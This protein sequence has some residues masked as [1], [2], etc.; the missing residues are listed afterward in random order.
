MS[1]IAP[2]RMLDIEGV[3]DPVSI[4]QTN[5]EILTQEVFEFN[6]TYQNGAETTVIGPP[7]T[8][9]HTVDEKWRDAWMAEWRCTVAGTPGTWRQETPAVRAGEP[10]S[11]TIPTNYII[12]D[13]NENYVKK[14]HAGS[15]VWTDVYLTNAYLA[16]L[17]QAG[18]IY[19]RNGSNVACTNTLTGVLR[20]NGTSGPEVI[21]GLTADRIARI[22]T[23]GQTLV[24]SIARDDGTYFAVG[25][26]IDTGQQTFQVTGGISLI[27]ASTIKT[28]IGELT[29]DTGNSLAINFKIGG[30]NGWRI[31]SAS[32]L[33]AV[34]AQT[35]STTTGNLSLTPGTGGNVY[36]NPDGAV[37]IDPIDVPTTVL[38][39][40]IRGL[41][42]GNTST[43]SRV[44]LISTTSSTTSALRF[45][46]GGG[47]NWDQGYILY[48]HSADQMDFGTART[49]WWSI[50]SV[51][52]L[53]SN[54][55]QTI[56]SSSGILTVTGTGGLTL[57][58]AANT[59]IVFTPHGTGKVVLT[60]FT[61][62]NILHIGAGGI[63]TESSNLTWEA[64]T[65]E[66]KLAGNAGDFCSTSYTAGGVTVRNGYRSGTG[67]YELYS[68]S[69]MLSVHPTTFLV[70]A[71]GGLTFNNA[72][73]IQTSSGTLTIQ[74]N[75]GAT[76][77]NGDTK[78]GAAG[79]TQLAKLVVTRT[80]AALNG[81]LALVNATAAGAD[82][83]TALE[84][85][86]VS[87]V[88]MGNIGVAWNG[89]ATTDAYM[90]FYTRG[91]GSTGEKLRITSEGNVGL[92]T[93]SFG[94]N[95]A[96]VLAIANGTAP[97]TGPSDTVQFY[98][99]DE[100]AGHTIPSFYCEGTNVIATGQADSASSV[101]VKM[102]INGTVVTLL[103][104]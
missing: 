58:T 28:S 51:G 80:D 1:T 102:R 69:T 100:S 35:I 65:K 23:S 87:D 42:V 101:R 75:G 82:R 44:T 61:Q 20:G 92:G 14:Y 36:L 79:T 3:G 76:S 91:S 41:T 63:I 17:G 68:T 85:Y 71:Y 78:I 83:G 62:N 70:T 27:G 57:S 86:G 2:G 81:S 54:G 95:A 90:A 8:G 77:I 19:W 18:G 15:Y 66:L 103:A 96:K 99:S 59:N 64:I 60:G 39:V 34:G 16:S 84:Y 47:S 72:Q 12:V 13:S 37:A 5:F 24:N 55:A 32:N 6:S 29:I 93:T 9:T 56:Q 22:G 48:S 30:S 46:D 43:T 53:E 45:A 26:A 98:S 7:T 33:Q 74:G 89:A 38:G 31:T 10:A 40:G 4:A 67:L 97:T 88:L 104:V 25:G 49:K 73:T 11:G 94:T 21:S 52:I 50:T